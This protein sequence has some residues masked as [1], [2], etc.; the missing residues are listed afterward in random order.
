MIILLF[1]VLKNRGFRPRQEEDK[2]LDRPPE[3]F[4]LAKA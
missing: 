3:L 1:M 4:F 2:N